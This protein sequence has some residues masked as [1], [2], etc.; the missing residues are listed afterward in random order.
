MSPPR[1]TKPA[2][3]ESLAS[4]SLLRSGPVSGHGSSG[5]H[6]RGCGRSSPT[7][8]GGKSDAGS[9]HPC[10]RLKTSRWR[11]RWGQRKRQGGKPRPCKNI[12][13]SDETRGDTR[14]GPALPPA[15]PRSGRRRQPE[16]LSGVV[17][18]ETAEVNLIE[19]ERLER[20]HRIVDSEPER[21]VAA[22]HHPL[23]AEGLKGEAQHLRRVGQRVDPHATYIAA[24]RLGDGR[25]C[26][27]GDLPALVEPRQDVREGA[28]AVG[29]APAN[30]WPA[31]EHAAEDHA[32]HAERGLEGKPGNLGQVVLPEARVTQDR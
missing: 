26:R 20:G 9:S 11:A 30:T 14:P 6:K 18:T 23:R 17:A 1:A 3:P 32:S 16:Q 29:E 22:Q 24:G 21:I 13:L 27:V 25:A 4:P 8:R 2:T 12:A 28:T 10:P 5:L 7:G 19:S 15:R 31:A